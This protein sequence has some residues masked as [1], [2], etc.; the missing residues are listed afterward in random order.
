MKRFGK[1]KIA[2]FLAFASVLSD[3]TQ[4][5]NEPKSHQTLAAVGGAAS[6]NQNGGFVNWV[7]NHKWQ[8]VA[9][10]LTTATVVTL[11]ALGI[12]YLIPKNK[13]EPKKEEP[14]KEEPKEEELKKVELK[15]K[16]PKKEELKEEEHEPKEKTKEELKKEELKKEEPKKEE[17]KKEEPKKEVSQEVDAVDYILCKADEKM[18]KYISNE[19]NNISKESIEVHKSRA[20]K[21]LKMIKSYFNKIREN[22]YQCTNH[23][24]KL[25]DYFNGT[26]KMQSKDIYLRCNSGYLITILDFGERSCYIEVVKCVSSSELNLKIIVVNEYIRKKPEYKYHMPEDRAGEIKYLYEKDLLGE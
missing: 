17:A 16:E 11:A 14:K 26:K 25:I 10:T 9:G 20:Q 18:K 8:L 24:E 1:N 12:K 6:K 22:N 15:K 4:A 5:M 2:L 13:E 23:I 19:L 7:K 3:K 21:I